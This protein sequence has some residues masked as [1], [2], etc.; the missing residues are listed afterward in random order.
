MLLYSMKALHCLAFSAFV[1][2]L[3]IPSSLPAAHAPGSS[4]VVTE[5]NDGDTVTAGLKS[6]AGIA[7]QV[8]RVRLIGIDAPE[9]NQEPWGRRAT[10]H[11]K[12]LIREGGGTVYLEFDVQ[13]R[14][15]HGRLLGYLWTKNG[16]LLNE[17]M[18]EDGL[19]VLFTSPPNVKYAERLT[20][21]QE[22]A[23]AGARGIWGKGGL[24]ASPS[25]WRRENPRD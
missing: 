23:K 5:V 11:L 9:L 3:V 22:K 12:R 2:C 21:A 24:T 4:C 25:Q 17:R 20:R 7:A 13:D 6:L 10:R 16:I 19:A 15:R 8:E 14:D 18:I 1:I